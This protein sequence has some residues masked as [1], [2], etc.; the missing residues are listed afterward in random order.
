MNVEYHKWWSPSLGQ[1]MEMK[2]Y[3]HYG[4]P[5]IVFPAQGGLWQPVGPAH[6]DLAALLARLAALVGAD[7]L[8]SPAPTD[9]HRPD[10]FALA[11]FAPDAV[12]SGELGPRTALA[13]SFCALRRVPL[14]KVPVLLRDLAR[15]T[16]AVDTDRHRFMARA[17]LVAVGA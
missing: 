1:D 2:V 12:V 9:S 14:D 16:V 17:R 11:R 5:T 4:K 10:A 8:G 6:R 13:L 7:N 15:I 3:G